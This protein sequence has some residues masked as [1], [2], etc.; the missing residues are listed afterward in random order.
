MVVGSKYLV[1]GSIRPAA[2]G[3]FQ[4]IG[5]RLFALIFNLLFESHVS[6]VTGS[7]WAAKKSM[8]SNLSLRENGREIELEILGMASRGNFHITEVPVT[9]RAISGVGSM[10]SFRMGW[11]LLKTMFRTGYGDR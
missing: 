4:K 2:M 11:R 5:G 10:N 1:D 3:Y 6:D 7:F 9:F 8:L